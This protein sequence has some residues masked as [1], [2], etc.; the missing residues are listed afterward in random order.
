MGRLR[1]DGSQERVCGVDEPR[2]QISPREPE[3]SEWGTHKASKALRVQHD[4]VGSSG[5]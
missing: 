4:R 1:F 5:G 3:G 2:A